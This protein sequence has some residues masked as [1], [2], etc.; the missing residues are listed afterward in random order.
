MDIQPTMSVSPEFIRPVLSRVNLAGWFF[1]VR[2]RSVPDVAEK[3]TGFINLIRDPFH[4]H[5]YLIQIG[6]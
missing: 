6:G 2:P 5:L 3:P 1:E 4:N